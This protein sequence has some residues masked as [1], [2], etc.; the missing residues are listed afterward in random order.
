MVKKRTDKHDEIIDR[1]IKP[2]AQ[3]AEV[4]NELRKLKDESFLIKKGV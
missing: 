4:Q 3:M 2:E 1:V